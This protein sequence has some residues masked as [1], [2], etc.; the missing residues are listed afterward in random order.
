MITRPQGRNLEGVGQ[1]T[2]LALYNKE[3]NPR[4]KR[5]PVS[6]AGAGP[7]FPSSRRVRLRRSSGAR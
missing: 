3:S 1:C 5:H 2:G 6:N 4:A 7:A